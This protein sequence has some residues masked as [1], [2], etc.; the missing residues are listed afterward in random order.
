MANYE[1]LAILRQGVDIWNRWREENP[2]VEIDLVDA[3]LREA[4][5]WMANLREANLSG[6]YL[7]KASLNGTSLN[8]A[9]LRRADL[10][11]AN[12]SGAD[13][14]GA[15]LDDA[16]LYRANLYKADLREADLSGV[17]L[18][19]T[20]FKEADLSGARL[21]RV[22]L[23]ETKFNGARL[24]K[25]DLS[26][27][28]LNRVDFTGADLTGANLKEAWFTEVKLFE[29]TLSSVDFTEARLIGADLKGAYLNGSVF[30]EARLIGADLRGAY[31]NESVFT[32]AEL[33]NINLEGA[34][35]GKAY[36]NAT[37]LS[38][39]NLKKTYLGGTNFQETNLNNANFQEAMF[40]LTTLGSIDL[41]SCIGLETAKHSS[42]SIIGTDTIQKSKG[43]IPVE[44]LRGCGLSDL[45]IVYAKLAAPGLDREEISQITYEMHDLYLDQ[46]IQFYSCFISYNNKD[47]E[48]AQRLHDDLQNSGVRCWFAPEDMKIG[49]RIRP[50]IDHQIRMREK[51]IVILSENSIQSEWVGDEVEAAIEQEKASGKNVLFPISLDG[52]VF[53]TRDDWAAKI[54]RRISIGDFSKW[55]NEGAYQ[56]MFD[57]LLRDLKASGE[58]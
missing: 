33:S 9:K 57:R 23:N 27:T 7:R 4:N 46:P 13:L 31:L 6:A 12:L 18:R 56:K 51:L 17:K 50:T 32:E 3:N 29:C 37:N 28:D 42:P 5:L 47:Q 16:E 14:N 49:D 22:I 39:A 30:T 53:D 11:E 1:Q 41:S 25:T 15:Y 43:K 58:E 8:K 40:Q 26:H 54:K 20:D 38:E 35:L 24:W 55:K 19:K 10:T 36:L 52:A 34:S 2:D 48:F 45:D 44:F 21:R